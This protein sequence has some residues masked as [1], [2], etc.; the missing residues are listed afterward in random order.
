MQILQ[1]LR[2]A[3]LRAVLLV[4]ENGARGPVETREKQ[5][6]VVFQIEHR[7]AGDSQRLNVHPLVTVEGKTSDSAECGN[8]LI[9]LANG[10]AQ[11][12]DLDVTSL[13]SQLLGVNGLVAVSM[14][15]LQQ[16]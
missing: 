11:A 5:Q 14:Q 7:A 15:S 6:Q 4:F 10:L 1:H 8:E 3:G 9:L 12:L 16:R 2:F 13:L